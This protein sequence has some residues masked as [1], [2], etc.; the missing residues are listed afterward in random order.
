[1]KLSGFIL[2][3]QG[4]ELSVRREKSRTGPTSVDRESIAHTSDFNEAGRPWI[5]EVSLQ[6]ASDDVSFTV[7]YAHKQVPVPQSIICAAS[8]RRS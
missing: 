5:C 1:M 8:Q 3:I 4:K 7:R 6:K 2:L